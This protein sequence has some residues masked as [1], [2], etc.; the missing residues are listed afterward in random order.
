MGKLQKFLFTKKLRTQLLIGFGIT[1]FISVISISTV[2]ILSTTSNLEDKIDDDLGAFAETIN[3]QS[4][5]TLNIERANVENWA[6]L[7]VVRET[8]TDA[9]QLDP[10]NDL[11]TRYEG[12][13]W[14]NDDDLNGAGIAERSESPVNFDNDINP[15]ASHYFN[16][17]LSSVSYAEIF[18]TDSRGYAI[19]STANTGDFAQGEESWWLGAKSNGFH[20]SGFEFDDS[21]EAWSISISIAI[22]STNISKTNGEF[23]GVVKAQYTFDSLSNVV[24]QVNVGANGFAMIVSNEGEI[25]YHPDETLVG[26]QNLAD[27]VGTS[28]ASKVFSNDHF[29]AEPNIDNEK[30]Y[31]DAKP[32]SFDQEWGLDWFVLT[33]I[34]E[35]D[36]ADII[37]T[38]IIYSVVVASVSVVILGVFAFL[39]SGAIVNR[40]DKLTESSKKL[41]EGDLT[42][43]VYITSDAT[44]EISVLE[45]SLSWMVETLRDFVKQTYTS[46]SILSEST[47]GMFSSTE[48][49]NASAE[50]VSS[51]SLSMSHGASQQAE[52]VTLTSEQLKK[53]SSVV[54]EI[55]K[56]IRENTEFSKNIAL[57][58][59]ILALNAGIEASRAGDYGRGFM[60]VAE[61]VRKLSDQ[62]KEASEK[63]SDVA[64]KISMVLQEIFDNA[65]SE[66]VNI[67]AVAE[68]TAASSEEVAAAAEEMTSSLE[69]LSSLSE[70][71]AKQ[72]ELSTDL[73]KTFKISD[74]KS[75]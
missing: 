32:L 62:S 33:M 55:V 65:V 61:N 14:G 50:E 17:I 66:I 25:I 46:I 6:S 30:Y 16:T 69:E 31:L 74:D 11:W 54:A 45:T 60:V 38:P 19:A 75:N 41:A 67:S 47:E 28:V 29:M 27:V 20:A 4:I 18:F 52:M 15:E 12:E 59:N 2:S 68:E 70:E 9:S 48:E 10:L 23:A 56:E 40:I 42:Q 35:S 8:A 64:E 53:A 57:Q 7:P 71:L 39:F 63:I 44:D 5:E 13:K 51:T 1:L 36:V 3:D 37:T 26:S 34:P 72:A 21:S 73:V 43:D 22:K 24:S 58:T 49:M